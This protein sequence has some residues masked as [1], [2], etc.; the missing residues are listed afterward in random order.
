MKL[1]AGIA[2]QEGTIY[3]VN[4]NTK[5]IF[6]RLEFVKLLKRKTKLT[7]VV[8]LVSQNLLPLTQH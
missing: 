3:A 1:Y 6:K 7:E 8:Y 5:I 2:P 4:L